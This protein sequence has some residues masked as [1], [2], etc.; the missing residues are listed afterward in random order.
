MLHGENKNPQDKYY[1]KHHHL[2]DKKPRANV[3]AKLKLA[4]T[5]AQP[6]HT[7]D[8]LFN[9][10]RWQGLIHYNICSQ[11]NNLSPIFSISFLNDFYSTKIY[12]HICYKFTPT[13]C[14]L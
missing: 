2:I 4:L 8:K 13:P 11:T 1:I 10:V 9:A 7:K 3:S 5:F 12:H 14:I 6:G